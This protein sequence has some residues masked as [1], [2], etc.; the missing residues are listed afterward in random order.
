MLQEQSSEGLWGL[1]VVLEGSGAALGVR[2]GGMAGVL[3]CVRPPPKLACECYALL[4][5]LGRGF[6]QG[7][8]HT[9]CWNQEV[10]GLLATLHGLL[11][12]LFEGSESGGWGTPHPRD[13][14]GGGGGGMERPSG[15]WRDSQRWFWGAVGARGDT[16]GGFEGLWGME[17]L[18]GVC[19]G[20]LRAQRDLEGGLGGCG[21]TE[22]S[23]GGGVGV[24]K[25]PSGFGVT[26]GPSGGFGVTERPS[27]GVWG[28][29]GH[30]ETLRARLGD[31]DGVKALRSVL[32]GLWT[33]GGVPGGAWA[34][35]LPPLSPPDPLPY[36]G[37]G[38]ELLLPPPQ[39]GD[40]GFVL[41]LH[42][43]FSGLARVLQLLLRY[44]PPQKPLPPHSC[45]P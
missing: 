33:P 10:Q 40:T 14:R 39:D 23:S 21:G 11:G 6:S 43:R 3:M 7:L 5:A 4:P 44:R 15:G 8:R 12:A 37:P 29:L 2:G 28:A 27:E 35:T 19:W 20:V 36:E 31:A 9:E 42:N 13:P 22:E 45:V 38:V 34:L 24:T 25:G 41:T 32:G 16:W 18:S 17:R 1:W 26:E 30:R